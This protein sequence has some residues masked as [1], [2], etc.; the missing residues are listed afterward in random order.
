MIG[1]DGDGSL[2]TFFRAD[3]AG[4]T[5]VFADGSGD[6]SRVLWRA[7]Y[8]CR[9]VFLFKGNKVIWA[10]LDAFAAGYTHTGVYNRHSVHNA[11]SAA[12]AGVYAVAESDA[13]EGTA[14]FSVIELF[15][16]SAAFCAYVL[17]F[18]LC[19]GIAAVTV[20]VSHNRFGLFYRH[21]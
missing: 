9:G 20:N 6:F 8:G 19:G 5:A 16:G 11:Y 4:D 7:P 3:T 13:A 15:G 21:A 10:R 1:I 12:V 17:I 2:R 14:S 18:I